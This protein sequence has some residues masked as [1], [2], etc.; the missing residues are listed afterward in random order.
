VQILS[1]VKHKNSDN[2]SRKAIEEVS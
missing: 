2:L 1:R